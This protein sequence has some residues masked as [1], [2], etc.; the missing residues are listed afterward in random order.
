MGNVGERG[1]D[2]SVQRMIAEHPELDILI[3]VSRELDDIKNE[4][5][6]IMAALC[7]ANADTRVSEYLM[8]LGRASGK[9]TLLVD[10]LLM[11]GNNVLRAQAEKAAGTLSPLET[12]GTP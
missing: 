12:G 1:Q 2:P 8:D 3:S 9:A 10:R 7:Q 5:A 6:E 11:H 4:A